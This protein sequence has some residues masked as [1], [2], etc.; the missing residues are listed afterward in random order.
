MLPISW[1]TDRLSVRDVLAANAA[2]RAAT[3]DVLSGT[4]RI[5]YNRSE[6]P[7]QQRRHQLWFDDP[8]TL[9]LK[10]EVGLARQ[11]RGFGCW[12]ADYAVPAAN[13]TH[14]ERACAAALW[15]AMAGEKQ[16]QEA[17]QVP[18]TQQACNFSIRMM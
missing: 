14:Q 3:F 16:V 2:T 11:V 10:R 15:A 6:A 7:G 4:N 13:A 18:P 8:R 9:Q 1:L 5:D 17:A 12:N